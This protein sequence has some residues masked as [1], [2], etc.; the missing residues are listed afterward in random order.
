MMIVGTF[1]NA[2]AFTGGNC[3]AKHLSSDSRKAVLEEKTQH[4]KA[5]E[6]NQANIHVA[7]SSS[8][9]GSKPTGKSKNW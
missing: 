5:L 2:A 4:N 3:L 7:A 9:I 1:P 6:A 8:L